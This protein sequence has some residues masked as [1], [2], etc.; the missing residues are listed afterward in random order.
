MSAIVT[1]QL[2]I[3]NAKNFI[4]EITSATNNY[5]TFVGLTNPNEY[6]S[7]WDEDPPAPKDNFDQEN[8]NWD[9]II[10]LKKVD[11]NNVRFALKKNTWTSGITYDMYRHDVNRDKVCLL[12]TSPSPRD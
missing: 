8:H 6:L 3:L 12:Y 7:T 2:R 10:G 1:D 11:S 9:T 5:Y 4:A